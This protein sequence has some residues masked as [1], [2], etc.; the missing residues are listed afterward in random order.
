MSHGNCIFCGAALEPDAAFCV[1]CG[2]AVASPASDTSQFGGF[3]SPVGL[4]DNSEGKTVVE[5]EVGPIAADELGAAAVS[6]PAATII[7]EPEPTPATV[8]LEIQDVEA[9]TSTVEFRLGEGDAFTIG[10]DGR[11]TNYIPE[12]PRTS[13]RH[14][15]I[16]IGS[17]G[18]YLTDLGSSNGT[19][20]NS[21]RVDEPVWLRDGDTIEY[22]RSSAVLRILQMPEQPLAG[23]GGVAYL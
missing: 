3:D 2:A 17:E 6:E 23:N 8:R 1:A 7:E 11:V 22:G 20:V 4:P 10:R 16:S 19:Y 13:R 15:S 21:R 12:D 18:L 5:E 9:G 14:F